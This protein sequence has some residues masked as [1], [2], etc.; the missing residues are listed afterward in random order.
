MTTP[1]LPG[2]LGDPNRT[3]AT[4]P[5]MDPRILATLAAVGLDTNGEPPPFGPDA[6]TEQ[7][8]GFVDAAEV[9]FAGLFAGIFEKVPPVRGVVRETR[10]LSGDGDNE[11]TLYIHRPADAEGPLPGVYHIHGGGMVLLA[12]A[13]PEYVW[14]R[15][16]QAAAGMVVV[17]VEYRNGAGALGPYPY[18]A[19]LD[20]CVAGLRHTLDH[21]DELGISHL[22]VSGE[23][24][25]GNLTLATA[26]RADREGW[27]DRIAGLYAECPYISGAY[28]DPPAELTS[29]FENNGYFLRTDMMA[30][31]VAAY[32][33]QGAN[34][35]EPTAWPW[36]A[37]SEDLAGFP[38]TVI[39]VNQLDPLRDEG[40]SFLQKL[41]AAGVS[42]RGR[43]VPG[44]THAADLLV[45][46]A[47]APEVNDSTAEDI[48]A[49]NYSL[50]R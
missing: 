7:V 29:L 15:D 18:P 46:P 5:R 28:D 36:Y 26:I 19:G 2:R 48:R 24:G 25:G 23:S 9:G 47:S 14:W 12:A 3:I 13:N 41:W 44:T 27:I 21:A 32:D 40:L 16:R 34:R 20:D 6:P 35:T 38:P 1:Q 17:G 45:A 22:I 30:L 31:L 50:G 43:I 49:F 42:A 37:S 33:P 10:T 4:D 8:L 11:I 39:S